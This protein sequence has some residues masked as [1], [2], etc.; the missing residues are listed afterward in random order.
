MSDYSPCDRSVFELFEFVFLRS[1]M[2]ILHVLCSFY[3][4]SVIEKRHPYEFNI[5]HLKNKKTRKVHFEVCVNKTFYK[6]IDQSIRNNDLR[7]VIFKL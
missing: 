1:L 7:A 4:K 5:L 6:T 3:E 2:V